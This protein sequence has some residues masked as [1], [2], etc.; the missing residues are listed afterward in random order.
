MFIVQHYALRMQQPIILD[1]GFLWYTGSSIKFHSIKEKWLDR[2]VN[3]NVSFQFLMDQYCI[4]H[5]VDQNQSNF[6]LI[7]MKTWKSIPLRYLRN[8]TLMDI[9][10]TMIGIIHII[11]NRNEIHLYLYGSA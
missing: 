9:I 10:V 4:E 1:H 3:T 11:P 6:N 5:L 8:A 2:Q 7:N